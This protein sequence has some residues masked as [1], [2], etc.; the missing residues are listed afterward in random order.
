[1]FISFTVLA[2]FRR[3]AKR[4]E[5]YLASLYFLSLCTVQVLY[6]TVCTSARAGS[7][8]S[9]GKLNSKKDAHAHEFMCS[10]P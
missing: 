5:L 9:A 6:T 4:Q 10:Y 1:M 7:K 8:P 2:W 3:D